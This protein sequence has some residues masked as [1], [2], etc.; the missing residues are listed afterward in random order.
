MVVRTSSSV[1][2][3]SSAASVRPWVTDLARYPQW[4]PLVHSAETDGEDAWNVEIRA[5]VG[6][7]ARSKRLRMRR[8][9]DEGSRV[10]FERAETDG[11]VHAPWTLEVHLSERETGCSVTVEMVY[12]GSLWTGGILDKVLAQ[13]IEAGKAGLARVTRTS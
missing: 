6:P 13:Q 1:D 8:A 7:L 2:L 4:M 11:K 3:D 9:S 5:R 12:G 10:R